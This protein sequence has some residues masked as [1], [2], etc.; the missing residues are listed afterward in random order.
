[1]FTTLIR[2]D[3]VYFVH[4]K[5]SKRRIADFPNLGP[6]LAR[7]YDTPEVKSTVNMEHIRHHYYESHTGVNPHGIVSVPTEGTVGVS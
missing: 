3:P 4:F 2:F 1:M 7:L 6:Y 5:C